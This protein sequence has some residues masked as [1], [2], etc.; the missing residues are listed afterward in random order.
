ML[1]SRQ[2]TGAPAS[3]VTEQGIDLER[4]ETGESVF[5]AADTV[6]LAMGVR[7]HKEV[8]DRFKAAFPDAVS[9]ATRCAAGG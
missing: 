6:I 8:V 7:P 2:S 4:M 1:R 3:E 9:W 5:V